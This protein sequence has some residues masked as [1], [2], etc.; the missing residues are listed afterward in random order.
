MST[1]SLYKLYFTSESTLVKLKFKWT[2]VVMG[3]AYMSEM[4]GVAG[5]SRILLEEVLT[6]L[7][8]SPAAQKKS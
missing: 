1:P 4:F 6:L 3:T 7:I 8:S 5:A 2:S